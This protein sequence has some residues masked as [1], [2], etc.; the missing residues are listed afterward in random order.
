MVPNIALARDVFIQILVSLFHFN[1]RNAISN[2]NFNY[3]FYS[4]GSPGHNLLTSKGTIY[5]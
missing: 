3:S 4:T 1:L 5:L 2:Y